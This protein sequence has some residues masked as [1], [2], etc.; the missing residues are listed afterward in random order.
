MGL[1]APA[2][3]HRSTPYLV[4]DGVG[5]VRE[6]VSVWRLGTDDAARAQQLGQAC[7]QAGGPGAHVSGAEVGHLVHVQPQAA[8][9][10][11]GMHTADLD[12]GRGGR[13]EG[14][15][16]SRLHRTRTCTNRLTW[17]NRTYSGV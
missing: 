3:T 5:W 9:G 17:A 11:E 10:Y 16:G 7:G 1:I 6:W 14:E 13:G 4:V 12:G 8:E 15:A 2:H